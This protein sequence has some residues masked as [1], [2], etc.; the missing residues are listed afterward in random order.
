M[1]L[2]MAIETS[3]AFSKLYT[4]RPLVSPTTT[5]ALNES[6]LPPLVTLVIRLMETTS[7]TGSESADFPKAIFVFLP[8]RF[9]SPPVFF[10]RAGSGGCSS[11]TGILFILAFPPFPGSFIFFFFFFFFFFFPLPFL[12]YPLLKSQPAFPRGFGKSL[13]AT[14]V[15]ITATVKANFRDPFFLGLGGEDLTQT[16]CGVHIPAVLD[17]RAHVFGQSRQTEED[18][19]A[20]II[21]DLHIKIAETAVHAHPGALVGPDDPAASSL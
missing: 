9:S 11:T 18:L 5:K 20:G 3:A 1:D 16:S 13:H 7:S 12:L 19:A 21:D 8:K 10:L 15:K 14:V 17:L 2:R 6:F 4:T